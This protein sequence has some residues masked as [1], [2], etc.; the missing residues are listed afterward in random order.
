[1]TTPALALPSDY[2]EWLA[3]LKARIRSA[4]Q[5]ALLAANSEQTRLYHDIGCDILERQ[6]RQGWGAKVID[7]LSSDLR[8]A[9]PDMKGLSTRNLKYMKF[10]AEHC[11]NPERP[12]WAALAH[13]AGLARRR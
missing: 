6:S 4:R 2:G 12:N 13:K 8:A 10:F 3:S 11:P 5:R 1:M 9:F 7:R